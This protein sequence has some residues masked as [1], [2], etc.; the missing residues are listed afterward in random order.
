M[1]CSCL[2]LTRR[3]VLALGAALTATGFAP[4]GARAA[5]KAE[6]LLLSCMDYRLL[7]DIGRYMTGQGLDDKYDHVIL[8]GAALGADN[9]KFPAWPTTF[10][11]HLDTAIKLHGISRVIIMDH[12]DCGAYRVILGRDYASDPT[13]E[14]QVHAKVMHRLGA[15]IARKYPS[16]S[17]EYFLMALDGSVETIAP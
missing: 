2:T 14:T 6:A 11:Q 12:R 7:D 10:W 15:K 17:R 8:A 3:T 13:L 16:L 1:S 5:G 4:F 9:T